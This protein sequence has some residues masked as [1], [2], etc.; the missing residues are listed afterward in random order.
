MVSQGRAKPNL[1]QVVQWKEHQSVIFR[2]QLIG[3]M[4]LDKFL[5][6]CE[7]QYPYP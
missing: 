7:F 1:Q 3:G 5:N 2:L 6:P 4:I